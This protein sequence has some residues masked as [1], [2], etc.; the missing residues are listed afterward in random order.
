[1][2]YVIDY[3]V[4]FIFI[5]CFFSKS[6]QVKK[7]INNKILKNILFGVIVFIYGGAYQF[8]TD[9]YGYINYFN[10]LSSRN[11]EIGYKYLN[12]IFKKFEMSY[13]ELQLFLVIVILFE[14]FIVLNNFFKKQDFFLAL[15]FILNPL[16]Y[17]LVNIYRQGI[18][19]CTMWIAF[20]YFDIDK[21]KF[22]FL[23]MI[24]IF[25]HK[26]AIIG[27]LI[28]L[29]LKKIR[30]RVTRKLIICY[31]IYLII[32]II[33]KLEIFKMIFYIIE[34]IKILNLGKIFILYG[35]QI[36]KNKG[37]SFLFIIKAL[38]FLIVLLFIYKKKIKYK[39]ISYVITYIFLYLIL[40]LQ[41]NLLR[42]IWVFQ[43]LYIYILIKM[44]KYINLNKKLVI[45]FYLLV[46]YNFSIIPHGIS[47]KKYVYY[48]YYLVDKTKINN[49]KY[50]KEMWEVS[51][52]E[53]KELLEDNYDSKK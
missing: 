5:L 23:S 48:N 12:I 7:Y 43:I 40:M 45:L 49:Y 18:A 6:I 14:I 26:S 36:F 53:N 2:Y 37:V 17:M 44:F 47:K 33:F 32:L 21:K 52:E 11:L 10:N 19:I 39:Y 1:M 22:F 20:Y 16:I 38:E 4:Y 25:F 30:I 41:G 29:L 15:F 9:W 46:F 50:I 51:K 34:N 13:Q 42:I 3:T 24:A 28:F 8:G 35:V 27:F 31:I